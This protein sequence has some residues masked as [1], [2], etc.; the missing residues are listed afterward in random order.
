MATFCDE[1]REL[2]DII[3]IDHFFIVIVSFIFDFADIDD[4]KI[5]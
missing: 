1:S 2:W 4:D 5:I 3:F